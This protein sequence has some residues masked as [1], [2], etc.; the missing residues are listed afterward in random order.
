MYLIDIYISVFNKTIIILHKWM[1]L[2]EYYCDVFRVCIC[3][4]WKRAWVSSKIT[5]IGFYF[6]LFQAMM[7]VAKQNIIPY[8][9]LDSNK[10]EEWRYQYGDDNT[11]KENPAFS[12]RF[13][14]LNRR[15]RNF[16]DKS[17]TVL[18][19]NILYSFLW[20]KITNTLKKT[21]VK[22]HCFQNG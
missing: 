21:M 14:F 1:Q 19:R 18:E 5:V 22:E 10:D 7:I 3:Y 4:L 20:I 11:N 13:M 6:M 16:V 9:T 8:W 17:R 2:F 12:K 15:E